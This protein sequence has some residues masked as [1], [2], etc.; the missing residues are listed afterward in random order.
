[1]WNSLGTVPNFSLNWKIFISD[2]DKLTNFDHHSILHIRIS[3]VSKFHFKQT[4]LDFGT[5][6]YQK[7]IFGRK[8]KKKT[9]RLNYAYPN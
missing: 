5:K 6:F 3:L 8:E 9:S 4:I 7:G 2:F 1:M